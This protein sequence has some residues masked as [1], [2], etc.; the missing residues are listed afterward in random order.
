MPRDVPARGLGLLAAATLRAL[1]V[2][3]TAGA[4]NSASFRDRTG[5]WYD[6]YLG[7][8]ITGLQVSVELRQ[9]RAHLARSS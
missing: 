1:L 6:A 2:V 7:L 5:D 3:G 8:D 9:A 4:A